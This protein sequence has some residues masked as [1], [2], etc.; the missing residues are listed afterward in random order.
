MSGLALYGDLQSTLETQEKIHISHKLE[1]VKIIPTSGEHNKKSL[2][3]YITKQGISRVEI[4][5]PDWKHIV[6]M[7]ITSKENR[8]MGK[9]SSWSGALDQISSGTE[10]EKKRLII[11]ASGN[12]NDTEELKRY[13]QDNLT[14]SIHDPAQ[15]WNSLTVGAVTDKVIITN[16]NLEGFKPLAKEKGQLSPFSTT[17]LIWEQ[18]KWPVK[19]DVVFE[20]GVLLLTVCKVKC[21]KNIIQI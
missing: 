5:R 14:N 19:P 15:S 20:G 11:L 3:G 8:N 1:S 12:V 2:Y 4:E 17:S 18:A 6:C 16:P 13:P 10:D 21:V 9:P 7:A